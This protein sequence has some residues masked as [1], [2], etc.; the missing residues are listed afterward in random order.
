MNSKGIYLVL[1]ES[2]GPKFYS[3]FGMII[4]NA[5]G[6]FYE[7]VGECTHFPSNIY[8]ILKGKK[9]RHYRDDSVLI[10]HSHYI[11]FRATSTYRGKVTTKPL[12]HYRKKLCV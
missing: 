8:S 9:G 2:T 7:K 1:P 5:L 6:E 11:S 10:Q 12:P 3:M 4:I